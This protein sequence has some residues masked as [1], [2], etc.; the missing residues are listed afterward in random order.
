MTDQIICVVDNFA[1]PGSKLRSEHGL[2][3]WIETKY[4]L[5]LFDT[6]ET[7]GTLR[8]NLRRL[9]LSLQDVECLALSHGHY[10]H[11][12]GL[13][14]VLSKR[15]GIRIFANPDILRP[16]YSLRDGKYRSIG[17]PLDPA[18]LVNNAN[19]QLSVQPNQI[20]PNLWTTGVINKRPE[21]PGGSPHLLV[22]DGGVWQQDPYQDDMSL[23][24]KTA[25][26]SVVICGCCHAGLLNTLFHVED[27]FEGPIRAVIGGTHLLS[28]DDQQLDHVI[29]IIQDRYQGIDLHLNHCTGQKAIARLSTV[30]GDQVRSCPAGTVL[31]FD[32]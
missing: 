32:D 17:L 15:N 16:R 12:G 23:V 18:V 4:G 8:H 22:R 5:L 7:K 13:E 2:S 30:L 20:F 19:L 27:N 26:G 1:A 24:L 28:A 6:G 25:R 29:S 21:P 14:L 11:T 3:L 10:D 9:H 31:I